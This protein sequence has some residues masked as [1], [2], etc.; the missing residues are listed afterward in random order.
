MYL[1]T[2]TKFLGQGFQKLQ[3]EQDRHTETDATE[4]MNTHAFVGGS[5][6]W[7]V[8]LGSHSVADTADQIF[9]ADELR[10]PS[11]NKMAF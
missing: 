7:C 1:H 5:D 10:R 3:H 9:V 4:R 2:K 11:S 6:K 8:V